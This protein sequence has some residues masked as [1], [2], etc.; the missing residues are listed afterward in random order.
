MKLKEVG[1]T[2]K[3]NIKRAFWTLAIAVPL[4][5]CA[6][7]HKEH[8]K[9]GTD[10][11]EFSGGGIYNDRYVKIEA[12][13]AKAVK[14]TAKAEPVEP[15]KQPTSQTYTAGE[16]EL[17]LYGQLK[18]I[19]DNARVVILPNG[20]T[21]ILSQRGQEIA[22]LVPHNDS[23]E[24]VF[25]GSMLSD[26]SGYINLKGIGTTYIQV[27]VDARK[28]PTGEGDIREGVVAPS[29][30]FI[31]YSAFGTPLSLTPTDIA[32]IA[33]LSNIQNPD[34]WYKLARTLREVN[35]GS[36]DPADLREFFVGPYFNSIL[37]LRRLGYIPNATADLNAAIAF[38]LGLPWLYGNIGGK[39][40]TGVIGTRFVSRGSPYIGLAIQ[41]VWHLFGGEIAGT[42]NL[43]ARLNAYYFEKGY[44]MNPDTTTLVFENR[45]WSLDLGYQL[46]VN[47]GIALAI[48][49]DNA[50]YSIYGTRVIY[51]PSLTQIGSESD[52]YIRP[53]TT[54]VTGLG[55]G[56]LCSPVTVALDGYWNVA[57]RAVKFS[58]LVGGIAFGSGEMPFIVSI[59]GGYPVGGEGKW[60]S[61]FISAGAPGRTIFGGGLGGGIERGD[62]TDHRYG[63]G[64]Y[65][66]KSQY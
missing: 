55:M 48:G 35:G 59:Q 44:I 38:G 11:T 66:R 14:D 23:V 51:D 18:G 12:D 7:L 25:S 15:V 1:H 53:P 45:G 31:P 22:R 26:S 32:G 4:V 33:I 9:Y 46:S 21:S 65:G 58:E 16:V 3:E 60:I 47:N 50:L 39:G 29:F 30:A 61:L 40:E 17:V 5:S 36:L 64:L 10:V 19:F 37:A 6:S 62:I 52:I 8:P 43:G 41:D 42:H 56:G 20:T 34:Q 49:V 2:V 28:K 27:S 57:D 24:V 13:T 63:L 54:L